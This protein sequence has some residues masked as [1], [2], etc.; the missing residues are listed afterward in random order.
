MRVIFSVVLTLAVI[1][2]GAEA[3][4]LESSRPDGSPITIQVDRPASPEKLPILLAIDGSLCI[5]SLMS[6]QLAS[7]APEASGRNS[8]ALLVVEKPEPTHPQPEVDGSYRIGPDFRCSDTFKKYYTLEQRALDHLSA[9]AHL[10]KHADW[11][12]GRLFIWGFSD[13]ARIAS[14]VGVFSP[15]T[16]RMVLGGFGGGTSM[17]HDLESMMCANSD[18][19]DTCRAD[20]HA[21]TEK[22]RANPTH[23]ES[24]LGDAN[25][26]ATWA[27]R[28]DAVEANVLKEARFPVLVFHGTEDNSVPVSSARALATALSSPQGTVVYHEVEGMGHG[29]GSGLPEDEALALQKSFLDWLLTGKTDHQLSG[30]ADR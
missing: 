2:N 1:S 25:T 13:G 29:L 8:Y 3:E 10:R 7:L 5:P 22:I 16:R 24:W 17:A 12:D 27:S 6:E 18:Q 9:L 19:P 20:F 11:W 15:E 4:T 14:R 23:L 28:L 30:R 26:Y 21:Q